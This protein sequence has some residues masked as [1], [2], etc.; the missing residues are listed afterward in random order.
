MYVS[1]EKLIVQKVYTWFILF[2]LEIKK[3]IFFKTFVFKTFLRKQIFLKCYFNRK[4][5]TLFLIV[6]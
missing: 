4:G 5:S 6:A 3:N 1:R 2:Y